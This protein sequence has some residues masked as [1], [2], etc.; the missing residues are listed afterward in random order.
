MVAS[1][2]MPR[3]SFFE[4]ATQFLG[5]L[6]AGALGI[7]AIAYLLRPAKTIQPGGFVDAADLTQLKPRIPEEVSF[8]RI[9]KDGW[10]L[11][12]EKSTAWVV[13]LSETEVV[14]YAPQCTHLGCAYHFE[15]SKGE[16][17]CPCHTTNFALD[18]RVLG[19]PAPRPLDRFPTRVQG[20]RLL[21]GSIESAKPA[22]EKKGA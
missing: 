7:P 22:A 16:F 6:L 15:E 21:I 3:R 1:N 9:R 19:G 17:V 13:K 8:Q 20:S 10:K 2:D 12:T 5:A 18:G 11:I 14:A 4:R